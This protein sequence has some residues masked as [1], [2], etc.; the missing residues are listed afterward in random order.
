MQGVDAVKYI[1]ET[2]GCEKKS[3][4]YVEFSVKGSR[5]IEWLPAVK[6]EML[7]SERCLSTCVILVRIRQMSGQKSADDKSDWV[8]AG[9]GE[10]PDNIAGQ[11]QN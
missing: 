5:E 8:R 6:G 7:E 1:S 11:W 4:Q 10:V 3:M 9:M 2:I